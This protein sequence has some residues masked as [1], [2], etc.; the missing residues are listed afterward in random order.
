[1]Q[2]I[3]EPPLPYSIAGNLWMQGLIN[4]TRRWIAFGSADGAISGR[5]TRGT[6]TTAWVWSRGNPAGN[7]GTRWTG[8]YSSTDWVLPGV[9]GPGQ[10][11]SGEM[12]SGGNQT[13]TST[14]PG[15]L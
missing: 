3:W 6:A 12:P 7:Q 14:N 11:T 9:D 4:N 2:A 5:Q 8:S 1:M 10:P 13:S 15:V